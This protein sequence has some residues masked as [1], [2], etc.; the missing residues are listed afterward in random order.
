MTLV[1]AARLKNRSGFTASMQ[2]A[3]NSRFLA[4]NHTDVPCDPTALASGKPVPVRFTLLR[5]LSAGFSSSPYKSPAPGRKVVQDPNAK[6]LSELKYVTNAAGNAQPVMDLYAFAK[7]GTMDKGPRNDDLKTT[8]MAG[9]TL[10]MWLD[11]ARLRDQ[12]GK[13]SDPI[14]PVG[15]ASIPAFTVCEL[16]ISPKNEDRA[17][18]GSAIKI[19]SVKPSAFSLY[20][21]MNDVAFL[22]AS[23]AQ[24]RTEAL[25]RKD[26]TPTAAKDLDVKDCPFWF[27]VSKDTVVDDSMVEQSGMV[28]LQ[29]TGDSDMPSVEIPVEVLLR[30]TNT[31][32]ADWACPLLEIAVSCASLSIMVFSSDWWAKNGGT[33]FRAVPLINVEGLL[34]SLT[35]KAIEKAKGPVVTLDTGF[36]VGDKPIVLVVGKEAQPVMT[37]PSPQCRDMGLSGLNV[38]LASAHPVSFGLEGTPDVWKGWFNASPIVMVGSAAG[39]KRR[40]WEAMSD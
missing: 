38:E 26:S 35:P 17:K 2:E 30:Y 25:G 12:G 9:D 40:R 34:A 16:A 37:G 29:N 19:V 33:G 24:A 7:V 39:Q 32:R 8:L 10:T 5:P 15:M 23:L 36:K 18:E 14:V 4:I 11:E 21:C 3:K 6:K 13:F 28:V 22:P 31:T 27:H 20:S 1:D